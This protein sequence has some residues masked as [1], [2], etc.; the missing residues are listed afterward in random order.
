MREPLSYHRRHL[1]LIKAEHTKAIHL[2]EWYRVPGLHDEV[3]RIKG[4]LFAH[5]KRSILPKG[6][7]ATGKQPMKARQR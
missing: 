7:W 2:R 4:E 3:E 6:R 1:M 5:I